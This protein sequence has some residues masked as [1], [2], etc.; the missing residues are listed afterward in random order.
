[1][2]AT[3]TINRPAT[4]AVLSLFA[5]FA[6]GCAQPRTVE[7]HSMTDPELALPQPAAAPIHVAVVRIRNDGE[8]P[9]PSFVPR[10]RLTLSARNLLA[11][12]ERG[13][14]DAGFP[15]VS[16]DDASFILYASSQTITGERQVYRRMPV[17]E[18]RHGTI[19]TRRGWRTFHGTTTTEVVV[20]VTRQFADRIITITVHEAIADDW[21]RPDDESAVWMG[22]IVG[23]DADMEDI[24]AP[25]VAELLHSWGL[26]DRRNVRVKDLAE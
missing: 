9:D 5:L 3:R 18:F 23:D 6:L 12:V 20:P 2:P 25:A 21:P 10:D 19:H 13:M 8:A 24:V 11:A 17:H 1:M 15:I 7:M 26:T 16:S 4:V 22:R 14:R